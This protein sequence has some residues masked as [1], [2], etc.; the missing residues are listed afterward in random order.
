MPKFT[1]FYRGGQPS[2]RAEAEARQ[3][4]WN[5]W[6]RDLG[7]RLVDRG[8]PARSLGFVGTHSMSKDV[9]PTTG[10][11]VI[12]AASEEEALIIAQSCP[13]YREGGVVEI[14]R[15]VTPTPL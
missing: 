12:D 5:A 15:F 10:Y 11:S 2:G 13:V 1:L 4:G 14:A 3:P 8:A 9:L 7:G 6:F